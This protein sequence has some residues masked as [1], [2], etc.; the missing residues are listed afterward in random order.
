MSRRFIQPR[1]ERALSDTRVVLLNGARQT[2]KST[3]AQQLA[4]TGGG[5]YV[6]LDDPSTLDLARTDPGALCTGSDKL[7]IIDEVQLAPEL[8]PAIKRAVDKRNRPGQFLLTGS[9]NVFLLP[10]LSESLAGRMEII[11]LHP[12]SQAELREVPEPLHVVDALFAPHDKAV[13]AALTTTPKFSRLDICQ[14]IV[15]GGYPEAEGREPGERRDAWFRSYV[16]SILQRDVRDMGNIDGLTALPRLFGLMA[17]RSSSL[18]NVAE[19]SRSIGIPVTTLHRYL[20]LLEATFLFQPLP[21]WSTNIGKRFVKAPKLHLVDPGL[22]A[23]LRGESDARELVASPSLGALLETFVVQEIRVL[24]SWGRTAATMYHYRTAAGREVDLVLE[25][26][27]QRVLGLEVKATSSV[28][29]S[30][31]AGLRDLAEAAGKQFVRGAIFYLGD[32]AL[33]FGNNLWAL[34]ISALWASGKLI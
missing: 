30:D 29:H 17:A 24:L 27:G 33:S 19:L 14:N 13:E 12:M 9:A 3:L 34:P 26:P 4:R 20:A 5:R 1:I 16:A 22:T 18:L 28:S 10:R 32:E 2:G 6:T 25:A 8:F 31:F 7:T 23:S 21:A 11:P 15:A